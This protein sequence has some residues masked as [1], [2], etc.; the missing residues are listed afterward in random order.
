MVGLMKKLHYLFII[1][2]I[3]ANFIGCTHSMHPPGFSDINIPDFS[4]QSAELLF[5]SG[6]ENGVI[7]KKPVADDGGIWWQQIEGSDIDNFF[8]PMN[9]HK[10]HT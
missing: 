10:I 2:L 7:L 3:I 1:T 6:F 4:N 9:I 8:W 5:K